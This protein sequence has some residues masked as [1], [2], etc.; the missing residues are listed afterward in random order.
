MMKKCICNDDRIRL[1]GLV[2]RQA[3]VRTGKVCMELAVVRI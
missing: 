1:V 2:Q 3:C